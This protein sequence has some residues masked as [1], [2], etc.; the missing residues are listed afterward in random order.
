LADVEFQRFG[1]RLQFF[2]FHHFD[3]HN[4]IELQRSESSIV[5]PE[6]LRLFLSV[7]QVAHSLNVSI[8]TVRRWIASGALPYRKVGGRTLVH[9]S[10]IDRIE[11]EGL[12]L[13]ATTAE[14]PAH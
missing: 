3:S 12:N 13:P 8:P 4:P 14:K 6:S 1:I 5:M 11:A 2:H 7:P 10:T 9:Q